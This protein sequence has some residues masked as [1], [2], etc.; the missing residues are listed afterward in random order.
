M[1]TIRGKD[2]RPEMVVRRLAHGLGYRYRIHRKGLPGS[3]DLA[4]PSRHKVIFVHGCFWHRHDCAWGRKAP[5]VRLGY[6]LPKLA[7]NQVRDRANRE[8]LE[9]LGWSVLVL[10]ECELNSLSEEDLA[11]RL[12][13]FLGPVRARPSRSEAAK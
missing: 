1:A 12:A 9:L 7:R 4:F 10:W 11:Q 13:S 8:E 5:R 6:W 3:P 2:T